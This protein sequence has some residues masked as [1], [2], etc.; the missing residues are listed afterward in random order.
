M[1]TLIPR[2]D[3]PTASSSS[4]PPGASSS[5][6]SAIDPDVIAERGYESIHRPT[7]GDQ[8][9]RERLKRLGIPTWAIKEDSYFPGILIPMYGP[10]GQRVSY[11]WKPARPVP[12][13]DGKP[14]K[15]AQPEGP[16]QPARRAPAE[17][18]QD[19]RPDRGAVDHRGRSR[20]LT[21]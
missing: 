11:Q 21:R 9:Q 2:L 1:I 3:R 7:N 18:R 12:N 13:R 6:E 4:T 14:M 15:Y 20:R 16:D 19:R 10:T 8:R 17:P 5:E